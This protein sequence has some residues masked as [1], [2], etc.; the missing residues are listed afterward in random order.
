MKPQMM[1]EMLEKRQRAFLGAYLGELRR[2]A[3]IQDLRV[4]TSN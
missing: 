2:K 1:G 4:D 3:K